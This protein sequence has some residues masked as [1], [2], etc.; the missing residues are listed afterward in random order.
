[1]LDIDRS[2]LP[3]RVVWGSPETVAVSIVDDDSKLLQYNK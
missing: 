3:S 1:M 2:S